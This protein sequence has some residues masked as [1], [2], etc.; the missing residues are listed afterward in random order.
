M[1]KSALL[2]LVLIVLAFAALAAAPAGGLFAHGGGVRVA[3][4]PGSSGCPG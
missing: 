2:L 4:Q 3:C 1:R